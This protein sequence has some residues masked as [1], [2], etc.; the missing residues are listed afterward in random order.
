MGK[1]LFGPNGA[2]GGLGGNLPS[3]NPPNANVPGSNGSAAGGGLDQLGGNLGQTLG[4]LI[5]QGLR[6]GQ[7]RAIP[8]PETPGQAQAPAPDQN[9]P[10]AQTQQES[11]PMN[12]VLR[13]LFNR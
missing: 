11:Q 13:Q 5:Q 10:S 8:A 1:G 12:D 6:Q 4:N 3:G 7:S 9:D 2:L